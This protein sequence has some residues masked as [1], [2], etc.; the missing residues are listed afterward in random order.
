MDGGEPGPA[1]MILTLLFPLLFGSMASFGEV[2]IEEK[3]VH[4]SENGGITCNCV[5]YVRLYKPDLPSMDASQFK[6]STTTPFI[7]AIAVMRYPSG[8]RHVAYVRDVVENQILLYHAN[9]EP[10]KERIEWMDVANP[11]LLGYQ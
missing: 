4:P 8:A 10:C 1:T 5:D 3:T 6:V 11:R 7:G 9:V 2:H